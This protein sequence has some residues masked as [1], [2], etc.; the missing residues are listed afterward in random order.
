MKFRFALVLVAAVGALLPPMAA[1]AEHCDSPIVL[2]STTEVQTGVE[3]PTNPGTTI[4]QGLPS[5]ASSAV[6]CSVMNDVVTEGDPG[7]HAATDTD[8][9]Y[10]G[11]NGLQVRLLDH[12]DADVITSAQLTFAGTT[13]D[14]H[15]QLT[16]DVTG[17]ESDFLDSETI[18]VDQADTLSGNEAYIKICVDNSEEL[19]GSDVECFE[20]TYKTVL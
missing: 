18:A 9:I 6:G 11:S 4:S 19:D 3:D 1:R 17:A 14:L 5:L 15:L 8:F 16:E 12:I 7:L 10:P 20:R 2:F 13:Y